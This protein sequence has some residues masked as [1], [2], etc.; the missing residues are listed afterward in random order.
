[1]NLP[2]PELMFKL[3]S[4]WL[5]PYLYPILLILSTDLDDIWIFIIALH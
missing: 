5:L 3:R 1:M 4:Q 2:A